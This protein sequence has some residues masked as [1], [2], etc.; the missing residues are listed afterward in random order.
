M[1]FTNFHYSNYLVFL[2][3]VGGG[4]RYVKKGCLPGDALSF[5]V[6]VPVPTAVCFI[7]ARYALNVPQLLPSG[8]C[9]FLILADSERSAFACS[10]DIRYRSPHQ[11]LWIGRGTRGGGIRCYWE[12][13]GGL[14][15]GRGDGGWVGMGYLPK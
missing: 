8:F 3:A 11:T 4:G 10:A 15:S 2:G 6:S 5:W 7:Y 1:R 14:R 9:F 12:I 13:A